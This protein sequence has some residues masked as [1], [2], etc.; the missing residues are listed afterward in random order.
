MFHSEHSEEVPGTVH[1]RPKVAKAAVRKLVSTFRRKDRG[2]PLVY[3]ERG[4]HGKSRIARLHS[5]LAA[6]R[7]SVQF[8]QNQQLRIEY[9]A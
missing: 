3:D 6:S 7:S 1:R 8:S 4:E 2:F 9:Q 5:R